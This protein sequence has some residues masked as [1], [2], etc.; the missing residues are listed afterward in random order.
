MFEGLNIVLNAF[1]PKKRPDDININSGNT[2]KK[3]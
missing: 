2:Q 1:K 3:V